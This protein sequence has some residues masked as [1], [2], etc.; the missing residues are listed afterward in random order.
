MKNIQICIKFLGKITLKYY[1]CHSSQFIVY[2][3]LILNQRMEQGDAE[4]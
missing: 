3:K 1:R 2:P 4:S